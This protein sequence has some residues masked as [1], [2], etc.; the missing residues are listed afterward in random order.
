[1]NDK[2]KIYQVQGLAAWGIRVYLSWGNS[3][4]LAVESCRNFA[5]NKQKRRKILG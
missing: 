2:T 3:E 4:L 1:M 5:L